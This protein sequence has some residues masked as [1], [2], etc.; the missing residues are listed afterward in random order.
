MKRSPIRHRSK[1]KEG[2]WRKYVKERKEFIEE[3]PKCVIRGPDCTD[4]TE[5]VQHA[6][7]RGAYLRD[8]RYWYPSCN[9]CNGWLETA[10]GKI[11]GLKKGFRVDRIGL[12]PPPQIDP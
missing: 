7:G 4:Q 6:I 12:K 5:S 9:L 3:N 10:E 11:Y 8:K 1:G 2:E